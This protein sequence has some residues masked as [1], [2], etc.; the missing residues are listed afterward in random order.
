MDI[1][2]IRFQITKSDGATVGKEMLILALARGKTWRIA[3][4]EGGQLYRK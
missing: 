4:K 3:K 2:L 1:Y